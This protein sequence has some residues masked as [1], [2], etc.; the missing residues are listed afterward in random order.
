MSLLKTGGAVARKVASATKTSLA[1]VGFATSVASLSLLW[2]TK[3]F[4]AEE[5]KE[6]KRVLVLPF[7]SLKLVNSHDRLSWLQSRGTDSVQEIQVQ[8]LVNI[9]HEAA[10]DP[11]IVAI[12]GEFGHGRSF[13]AG[14]ADAE[15]IRNVRDFDPP[16]STSF[17]PSSG[18]LSQTSF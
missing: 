16:I 7:H 17:Y 6:K 14:A 11:S 8:D 18:L 1:V 13:S 10:S 15:E 4:V 3:K 2:Q 9:I 5:A 12:F